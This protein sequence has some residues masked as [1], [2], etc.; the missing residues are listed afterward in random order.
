MKGDELYPFI[1]EV[2]Y[3]ANAILSSSLH[4]RLAIAI[5]QLAVHRDFGVVH[6]AQHVPVNGRFVLAAAFRVRCAGRE[7]DRAA[8]FFVKAGIRGE[9]SSNVSPR[10]SS[11]E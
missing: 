4:D 6:V 7:V 11:S 5:E 10:L 2:V 3:Q 1:R 8:D 9:T